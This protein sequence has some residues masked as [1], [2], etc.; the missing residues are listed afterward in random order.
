MSNEKPESLLPV[1]D[2]IKMLSEGVLSN[3]YWG[4]SDVNQANKLRNAA[5]TGLHRA[6][7]NNVYRVGIFAVA[8]TVPKVTYIVEVVKK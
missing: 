6:D 1:A 3:F 2:V 7:L 8:N 4:T 5:H